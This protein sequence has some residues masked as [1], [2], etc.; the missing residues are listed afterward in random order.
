MCVC[1]FMM[2]DLC[3]MK[4]ISPTKFTVKFSCL[5]LRCYNVFA[6]FL[7]YCL[8]HLQ[9]N[10][11]TSSKTT[12]LSRM[13][14]YHLVFLRTVPTTDW[15]VTSRIQ[16]LKWPCDPCILAGALSKATK[17]LWHRIVQLPLL[18]PLG[19]RCA[20]CRKRQPH[21][22]P[23]EYYL[24]ALAKHL[25]TKNSHYLDRLSNYLPS[26]SPALS[27]WRKIFGCNDDLCQGDWTIRTKAKSK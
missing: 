3:L 5:S 26:S 27:Q 12:P 13:V 10:M 11:A 8:L 15:L 24:M 9:S 19:Y 22:E 4:W 20:R 1:V 2:S 14:P 16:C 7:F 18:A 23:I 25:L 6:W 21:L 17:S